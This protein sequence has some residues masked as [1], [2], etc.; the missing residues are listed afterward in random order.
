MSI[1][2]KA[3]EIVDDFSLFSDWNDKYEHIFEL[4]KSLPPFKDALK[5]EDRLIKGCQSK[6]WLNAEFDG[7][8]M[9]YSAD[10]DALIT[11]GIVALIINVVNEERPSDVVK[12]E[13]GFIDKIGLREHLS[14]TR[15]NGLVSMVNQIKQQALQY[16]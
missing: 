14:M 7:E 1:E 3:I 11:K 15:S 10:S 2:S 8:K 5:T 9:N 13:F 6:V 16:I 4:G 12:Y